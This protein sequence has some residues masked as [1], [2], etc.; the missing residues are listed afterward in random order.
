MTDA[1][2]DIYAREGFIHLRSYFDLYSLGDFEDQII[3]LY[4]MQARKI[5]EYR[6]TVDK[7]IESDATRFEKIAGIVNLLEAKDAEAMYQV[8]KFFPSCNALR[9]LFRPEFLAFCAKLFGCKPETTLLDGPALFV[10]K[11]GV[12]RLLYRWHSEAQYYGKRRRFANIWLPIFGDR[13][14]ENGAMVVMPE[15]HRKPWH[16]SEMVEYAGYEAGDEKKRNQFR[17]LEICENF[18]ADYTYHR[19]VSN[20]GDV[21]IF[22]RN[23]V[24]ASSPNHSDTPAFAI[25]CRVWDPSD[26]L[27]L[28]GEMEAAPY[29][30]N[31]GRANLVVTP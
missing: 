11:P 29:G 9:S 28:S 14:I 5:G 4:H 20:R 1:L 16:T 6:Q 30:G 27:T 23:L 24:H 19:C 8:Q 18:L 15:S 26:D 22:D 2:A 21:I 3:A 10:N 31:Q 12:K 7:L 17:Q 13:T 25:V